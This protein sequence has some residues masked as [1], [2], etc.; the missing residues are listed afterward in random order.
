MVERHKIDAPYSWE[1]HTE[2]GRE[3]LLERIAGLE[4]GFAVE[5]RPI[6]KR[7]N[8]K[9]VGLYN[10]WISDISDHTGDSWRNVDKM[11]RREFLPTVHET[12]CGKSITVLTN[13]RDLEI[14][15]LRDLLDK[16]EAFN[17][18]FLDAALRDPKE[19]KTNLMPHSR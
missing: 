12:V 16:I 19:Y 17:G 10:G 3:I 6:T 8:K 5:L 9:Q 4:N 14:G 1:V 7:N 13:V 15:Q 18:E 2:V 11:I